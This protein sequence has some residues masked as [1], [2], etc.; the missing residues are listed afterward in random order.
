MSHE[1]D[2]EMIARTI[3][4][5]TEQRLRGITKRAAEL[6][7]GVDAYEANAKKAVRDEIYEAL[8]I[9]PCEGIT[10][11]MKAAEE[12]DTLVSRLPEVLG[13]SDVLPTADEAD[14][15]LL[16]EHF[17]VISSIPKP[18]LMLGGTLDEKKLSALTEL[19]GVDISWMPTDTGNGGTST[20]RV[21]SALLQISNSQYSACILLHGLISHDAYSKVAGACKAAKIPCV[22]GE[23]AGTGAVKRALNAIEHALKS[24][25][26]K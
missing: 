25:A 1:I 11:A 21:A 2:Y 4:Q 19:Y 22:S 14:E 13:L 5:T 7:S 12:L 16:D 26:G 8:G 10:D 24:G 23:R 9:K 20:P 6:R 15:A 3:R 17:P 18:V